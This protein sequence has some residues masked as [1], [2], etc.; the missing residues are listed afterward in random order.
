MTEATVHSVPL[1]GVVISFSRCSFTVPGLLAL[2]IGLEK[3]YRFERE[4]INTVFRIKTLIK[5]DLTTY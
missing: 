3:S 1:Q 5:L 2:W 4:A